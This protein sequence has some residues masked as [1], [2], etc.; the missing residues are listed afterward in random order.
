L[1][2]YFVFVGFALHAL[3]ALRMRPVRAPDALPA[4]S[5]LK[6]CAGIDDELEACLSSFCKLDYP[7]H[8]VIFAVAHESDPAYAVILDVLRAHPE[9]PAR[10]VVSGRGR[11]ANPKVTNLEAAESVARYDL[12]WLSDSNTRVEPDMLQQLVGELSSWRASMVVS[13]VVGDGAVSFGA[14]LDR[15][16]MGAYITTGALTMFSLTGWVTAPC[17]SCL[18]TRDA[19]RAAGGWNVLGRYVGED[20]VLIARVRAAGLRVVLGA[21]TV[22]NVNVR[23]TLGTFA[24]RYLRWAQIHWTTAPH[25]K[26]FEPL[27]AP[28]V[29]AVIAFTL[30]PGAHMGAL[31]AVTALCQCVGD[32]F[33]VARLQQEQPRVRD[34]LLAL[35]RP[36]AVLALWAWGSTRRRVTW[37][38]RHYWIGPGSECRIEPPLR[39]RMR[40]L[41]AMLR[42]IS[43]SP[44]KPNS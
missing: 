1:F 31:L 35:V 29:P 3:R 6:P 22:A 17:K 38:G 36:F 13:P 43:L 11:H 27:L 39:T 37:R 5:V 16:H 12:L 25:T 28:I 2:A 30:A 44:T 33:V 41:F 26:L 24:R 9:A 23:G 34:A 8:E 42:S 4:V 20:N 10:V 19:L 32:A 18:L 40:A 21:R 14:A 7:Q 15:L